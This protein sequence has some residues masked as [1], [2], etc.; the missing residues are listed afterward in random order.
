MEPHRKKKIVSSRI[1]FL[2]LHNT[3]TNTPQIFKVQNIKK[4]CF[5]VWRFGFVFYGDKLCQTTNSNDIN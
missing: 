3:T 1:C 2:S 5:G 4:T